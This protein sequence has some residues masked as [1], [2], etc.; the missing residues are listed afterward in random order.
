M[1]TRRERAARVFREGR[2]L[3]HRLPGGAV[4]W[5][6]IVLVIGL[7]FVVGGLILVPLPG[8][9]WLIVF[10]GIGIWATE[11]TWAQRLLVWVKAKVS[12]GTRWLLGLPQWARWG[13]AVA[14]VVVTAAVLGGYLAWRGWW[15]FHESGLA[16]G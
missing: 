7:V 12:A 14:T 13:G 8:P 4:I 6:A 10:I 16:A 1:T 3:V 2:R 15:P 9:G 11:F 5:D